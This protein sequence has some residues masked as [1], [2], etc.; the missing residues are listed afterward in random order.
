MRHSGSPGHLL[1]AEVVPR[2]RPL[3]FNILLLL[4]V[5]QPEATT[6]RRLHFKLVPHIKRAYYRIA[7]SRLLLI[8]GVRER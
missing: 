2:P 5:W 6:G 1:T 7:S 4:F 8:L 3:P